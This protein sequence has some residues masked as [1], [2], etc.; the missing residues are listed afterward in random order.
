MQYH[1]LDF[2]VVEGKLCPPQLL[3]DLRAIDETV[4]LI[5]FGGGDW[6]LGSVQPSPERCA[7]GQKMLDQQSRLDHP[8]P[9]NVLLSMLAVQGFAQIEQYTATMGI[10]GTV[11]DSEGNPCTV[12]ED[13]RARDFEWRRD[14]GE[15][16]FKERLDVTNGVGKK[17]ASDAKLIDYVHNDG[18]DHYR[19]EMRGRKVF[20][21]PDTGAAGS[22]ILPFGR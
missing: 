13:F 2:P 3:A 20:S 12:L 9:K 17:A 1:R 19:R 11:T 14:Q 18:R 7:Q 6:R 22:I 10:D 5:H 21:T 8:N 15:A 4:E 16:V